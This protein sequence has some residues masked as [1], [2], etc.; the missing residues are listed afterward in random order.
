[1]PQLEYRLRI[2]FCLIWEPF[3]FIPV[4]S[5]GLQPLPGSNK[6][7]SVQRGRNAAYSVVEAA[8]FA[9]AYSAIRCPYRD[10][11][12]LLFPVVRHYPL[13]AAHANPPV[14]DGDY[15]SVR[16]IECTRYCRNVMSRKIEDAFDRA[17]TDEI[18]RFL[19]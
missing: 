11:S 3:R 4:H 17:S 2:T 5:F 6:D 14:T 15:S 8:S 12:P 9:R 19:Y 10:L 7:T 16:Q 1:M 13:L 18:A